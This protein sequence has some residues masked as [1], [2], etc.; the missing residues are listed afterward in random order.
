MQQRY[1]L[2]EESIAPFLDFFRSTNRLA[3]ID[4]SSGAAEPIWDKIHEFFLSNNLHA[5]RPIDSILVF[6]FG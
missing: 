3:T 4:V 6:A 2:H 5:W 1:R